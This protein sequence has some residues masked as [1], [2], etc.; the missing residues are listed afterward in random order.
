MP[1]EGSI[2]SRKT[3]QNGYA[4][5]FV[6]IRRHW[7]RS[8]PVNLVISAGISFNTWPRFLQKGEVE[9]SKS[10]IER[11]GGLHQVEAPRWS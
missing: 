6:M 1:E 4:I 7:S 3:A 10:L 2:L 11:D 9:H 8:N 5:S